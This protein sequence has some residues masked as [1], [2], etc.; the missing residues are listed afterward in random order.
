MASYLRQRAGKKIIQLM[1]QCQ[2]MPDRVRNLPR[3]C[4]N[5]VIIFV[6]Y[7][8]LETDGVS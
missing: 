8:S 5:E 6:D 7:A 3:A 1:I 4:E 2:E